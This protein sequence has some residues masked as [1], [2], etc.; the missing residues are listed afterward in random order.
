[1]NYNKYCN[2]FCFFS[3]FVADSAMA[4]EPNAREYIDYRRLNSPVNCVKGLHCL[5]VVVR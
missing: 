5:V 4:Y 2:G 1:M 3:S